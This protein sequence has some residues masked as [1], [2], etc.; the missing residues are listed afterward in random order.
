MLNPSPV[1]TGLALA[2]ALSACT[3]TSQPPPTTRAAST[4]SS[5]TSAGDAGS[6]P[7]TPPAP[8]PIPRWGSIRG[9]APATPRPTASRSSPSGAATTAGWSPSRPPRRTRTG[10][11]HL[12]A[13]APALPDVPAA[14]GRARPVVRGVAV[15]D[16]GSVSGTTN[17]RA[18]VVAKPARRSVRGSWNRGPKSVCAL[19]R[20]QAPPPAS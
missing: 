16:E 14:P 6:S 17:A 9:T 8:S 19:R 1:P 15:R 10:L 13:E 3:Q 4:D 12:P 5:G 11:L 18:P 2:F 20:P 7:S